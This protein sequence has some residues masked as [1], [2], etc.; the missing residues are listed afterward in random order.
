MEP[1]LE[2]FAGPILATEA[3]SDI[4]GPRLPVASTSTAATA[5]ATAAT[6][7]ATA[8]TAMASNASAAMAS[9]ASAAMASATVSAEAGMPC[10]TV[11]KAP[12]V[13]VAVAKAVM[14]SMVTVEVAEVAK[15]AILKIERAID[16]IGVGVIG[17]A[18]V[19]LRRASG[20]EKTGADQEGYRPRHHSAAIHRSLHSCE[21]RQILPSRIAIGDL[22]HF[23]A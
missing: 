23:S 6:A 10:E 21:G 1:T 2:R 11:A 22:H 5:M 12:M 3:I 13:V 20:E 17:S 4:Y 15:A 19:R 9:S 8:A 14:E 18:I 16:R 7:M